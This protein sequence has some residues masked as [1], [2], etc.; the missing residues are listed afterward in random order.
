MHL[1]IGDGFK[2]GCGVILAGLAFAFSLVI[3]G[4][5]AMIAATLLSIPLPLLP[6][7]G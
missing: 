3:V 6:P 1:S 2:F 4:T 7:R 5:I